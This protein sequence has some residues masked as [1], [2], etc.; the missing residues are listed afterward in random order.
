MQI[1]YDIEIYEKYNGEDIGIKIL[2]NFR[3]ESYNEIINSNYFRPIEE[4]KEKLLTA[5][6][7]YC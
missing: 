3:Q 6:K 4:T 7:L 1:N 5:Y 2:K